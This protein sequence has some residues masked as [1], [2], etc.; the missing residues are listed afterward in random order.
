MCH[1]S[2]EDFLHEGEGHYFQLQSIIDAATQ[3]ASGMQYMEAMGCIHRDLA[4]RN[5]LVGG[6]YVY[7]IAGFHYAKILDNNGFIS[8]KKIRAPIRWTA[9][10][11]VNDCKF[12]V[13]SDVWSFGVLLVELFTKG[14]LPYPD[15]GNVEV[16]QAIDRGYRM[17][18]PTDCPV[19][20][21]EIILKCWATVPEERPTFDFLHT[22]LVTL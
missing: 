16:L 6:N 15:M 21:Y 10:E 19:Y 14:R 1:G 2:L 7:K 4:A 9:P 12:S 5:V 3:I 13:K 17:E 8:D 11:A 20:L 22:T 18:C